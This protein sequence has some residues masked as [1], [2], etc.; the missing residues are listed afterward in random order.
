MPG[1]LLSSSS[2]KEAARIFLD[3]AALEGLMTPVQPPKKKLEELLPFISSVSDEGKANLRTRG[4]NFVGFNELDKEITVFIKRV[5]PKSKNFIESLPKNVCGYNIKY[6]QGQLEE[7]GKTQIVAHSSP[8]WVI[9]QSK[10]KNNHYACGSSI[11]VGNAREAGS[12]GCLVKDSEGTIYGLSNNHVTGSC[13]HAQVGLPIL[14]PGVADVIAGG[15]N[16]FTIGHHKKTLQMNPGDPSI[17]NSLDNYDAAI[18]EILKL[19]NVT[20]FQ[21]NQYDTPTKTIPFQPGQTV[22]KVGRTTGYTIGKVQEPLYGPIPITYSADIYGFS[23]SVYFCPVYLIY[24]LQ[25]CFSDNGDSGSLIVTKDDLGE[26]FAVG[27]VVGGGIDSRA[28]GGKITIALPIIPIL[29]KLGVALVTN[30]N[31]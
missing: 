1:T 4:I 13:N 19:D 8:P 31:V 27:I 20:S 21:G 24:G 2:V 22:E 7:I 9:R 6:R 18:F 15:L 14:A 11:S 12:L 3:W 23:G 30:H 29:E 26:R 16:P 25:D 28:P 17:I 10:N 5:V